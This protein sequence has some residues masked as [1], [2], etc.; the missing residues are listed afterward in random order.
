MHPSLRKALFR[1]TP[2][3]GNTSSS[4]YYEWH[5]KQP[6]RT[7]LLVS[8]EYDRCDDL[9]TIL[10]NA[11]ISRTDIRWKQVNRFLRSWNLFSTSRSVRIPHIWMA[12]DYNPAQRLF[13]PPNLHFCIDRRFTEREQLPDYRNIISNDFSRRF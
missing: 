13:M 4:Y 10:T 5:L 12:F 9:L 7:D 6:E 2:L 11:N 1:I 8:V 3:L